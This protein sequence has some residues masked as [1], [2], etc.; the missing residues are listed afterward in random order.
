MEGEPR[1][2]AAFWSHED[3]DLATVKAL[4]DVM[5]VPSAEKWLLGGLKGYE[6]FDMKTGIDSDMLDELGAD[7]LGGFIRVD[8]RGGVLST[9][10][11]EAGRRAGDENQRQGGRFQTILVHRHRPQA[12]RRGC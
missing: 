2:R 5:S 11:H 6:S 12:V 3:G 1:E 10:A 9:D 8:K 4:A 7:L